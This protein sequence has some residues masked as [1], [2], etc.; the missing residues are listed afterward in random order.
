MLAPFAPHIAE[1]LWQRLGHTTALARR[2]WPAYD[3]AKLAESTLELPVQV[4]GK[5]RDK[6]T[7][8]ADAD[9][10]DILSAAEAAERVRPWV[11]GKTL[12]SGCT[13]RRSLSTWSWGRKARTYGR[14]ARSQDVR[15]GV[16]PGPRNSARPGRLASANILKSTLSSTRLPA[17]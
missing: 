9:E 10:A 2:P 5:L 6:I 11:E 1:E 14:R 3:E 12:A 16:R 13:C 8:P 7:V 15:R 4:N 17:R